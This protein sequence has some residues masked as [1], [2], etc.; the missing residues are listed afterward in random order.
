MSKMLVSFGILAL[1]I[2]LGIAD[3]VLIEGGLPQSV[4]PD[5]PY[6][7]DTTPQSSQ[8]SQTAEPSSVTDESTSSFAVGIQKAK[9]PDVLHT[10]TK[11]GLETA[12]S[13]ELTILRTVIPVQEAKVYTYVLLLN[14]DRAG[15][16]A[17]TE[18][19]QVKNY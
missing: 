14:G 3:A 1:M 13:D 15:L 2:C 18:S 6:I 4:L 7:A 5:E 11:I 16:I 12:T 8:S 19:P 9:G 17:W 10:L